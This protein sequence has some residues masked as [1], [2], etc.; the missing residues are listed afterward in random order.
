[1]G[2]VRQLRPILF[3]D[4]VQRRGEMAVFRKWLESEGPAGR[5]QPKVARSYP[6]ERMGNSG[7]GIMTPDQDSEAAPSRSGDREDVAR[8]ARGDVRAFARL[9]GGHS[10]PIFNLARPM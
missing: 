2:T 8:A 6:M 5:F 10:A 7:G 1:M 3:R 9:Y 4:S